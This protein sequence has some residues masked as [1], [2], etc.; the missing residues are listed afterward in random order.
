MDWDDLA[1]KITGPEGGLRYFRMGMFFVVMGIIAMAAIGFTPIFRSD[2][3]SLTYDSMANNPDDAPFGVPN[4]H[5]LGHARWA[6]G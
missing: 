6:L 1:W 4:H 2:E 5:A 3:N